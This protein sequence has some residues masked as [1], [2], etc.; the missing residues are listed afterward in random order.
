MPWKLGVEV[1]VIRS[2]PVKVF[3]G[4]LGRRRVGVGVSDGDRGAGGM[5]G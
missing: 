4:M 3:G 2:M 5:V 1:K